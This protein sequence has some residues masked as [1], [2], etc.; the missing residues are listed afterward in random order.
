MNLSEKKQQV[1]KT[2][3]ENLPTAHVEPAP[4]FNEPDIR[5]HQFTPKEYIPFCKENCSVDCPYRTRNET[6]KF[7][8]YGACLFYKG[9]LCMHSENPDTASLSKE[10]TQNFLKADKEARKA[11]GLENKPGTYSFVCPNC[12][13]LCYGDWKGIKGESSLHGKIECPVCKISL[14]V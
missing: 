13:T 8:R 10:K 5:F 14:S 2:E 6:Y 12:Q 3:T 4:E 11:A 1:E 9:S 7:F